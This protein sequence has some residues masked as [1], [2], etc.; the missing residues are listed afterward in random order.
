MLSPKGEVQIEAN[1]QRQK[2]P[3]QPPWFEAGGGG[4]ANYTLDRHAL[5]ARRALRVCDIRIVNGG[6]FFFG[7]Y[8]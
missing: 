5:Q 6:L 2:A 3:A 8:F 1:H 4:P 7:S